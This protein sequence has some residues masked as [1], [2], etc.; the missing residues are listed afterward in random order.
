MINVKFINPFEHGAVEAMQ[1]ITSLDISPGKPFLKESNVATGDVSGIIGITGD[2]TGALTVSFSEACICNIIS[3]LRGVQHAAVDKEVFDVVR[4]I[5][6]MIMAIAIIRIEKEGLKIH[7]SLPVVV[8]GKNHTFEPT[9]DSPSITIPFST[10]KETF[11]I[12]ILIKFTEDEASQLVTEQVK[13]SQIS[14]STVLT[15][16]PEVKTVAENIPTDVEKRTLLKK[17]LEEVMA[18]REGLL[19]QLDERAF[20][21]I[22]KRTKFKKMIPVLDAK[23]KR[24]RLDITALESLAKISKDSMGNP[25][26]SKHYQHYDK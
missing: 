9:P 15:P 5:T 14:A 16:V 26:I 25:V 22:S 23:I 20:M 18:A 21:D 10:G 12:D 11:F 24:L 2:V 1:K 8:F 17:Q 3:N 4:E 13:I 19:K 7:A 6:K